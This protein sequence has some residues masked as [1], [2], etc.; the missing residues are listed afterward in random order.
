MSRHSWWQ[1][2]N[3]FY[4][5]EQLIKTE[6]KNKHTDVTFKTSNCFTSVEPHVVITAGISYKPSLLT[7][8]GPFLHSGVRIYYRLAIGFK[9]IQILLVILSVSTRVE[10]LQ[11]IVSAEKNP[12]CASLPVF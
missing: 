4:I 10:Q 5:C 1:N 11:V 9:N 7:R 8:F 12:C 6:K 3:L 2:A